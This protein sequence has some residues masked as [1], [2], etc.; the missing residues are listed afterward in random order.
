MKHI[1]YRTAGLWAVVTVATAGLHGGPAFAKPH[2]SEGGY[3]IIAEEDLSLGRVT[4]MLLRRD[5]R[6]HTYL[7]VAFAND[8]VLV[9][10]VTS[11]NELRQLPKV[12]GNC[13]NSPMASD[14]VYAPSVDL[15][16]RLEKT[17]AY[18]IDGNDQTVY[19]AEHGKLIVMRF[20]RPITRDA[21]IWEKFYEG[22]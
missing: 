3:K 13:G 22:R 1:S 4:D 2:G 9:F 7:Y 10:E 19:V 8:T 15:P 18:A 21:E 5:R 11:A 20:D 14:L 16:K 6:G 17:D 12:A